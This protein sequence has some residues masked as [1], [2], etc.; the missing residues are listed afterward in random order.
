MVC[1]YL[2]LNRACLYPGLRR[3]AKHADRSQETLTMRF[4][5]AGRMAAQGSVPGLCYSDAGQWT[6]PRTGWKDTR[7]RSRYRGTKKSAHKLN[8]KF[9]LERLTGV[10][11]KCHISW[12]NIPS[13]HPMKDAIVLWTWQGPSRQPWHAKPSRWLPAPN[14][15]IST[16]FEGSSQ[17]CHQA[18]PIWSILSMQFKGKVIK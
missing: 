2:V 4:S 10:W 12:A 7:Q 13:T 1:I 18:R 6:R 15:D 8:Q 11:V 5:A 3:L 9:K 16:G 17:K 14:T